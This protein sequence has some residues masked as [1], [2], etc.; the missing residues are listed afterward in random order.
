VYAALWH[1]LPGPWPV[2][3]VVLV[4]LAAAVVAACFLWVFPVAAP[5]LPF[6]QQTV[7]QE[8]DP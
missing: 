5:H 3:V 4:L 6:N 1:V 8:D 2:R 7:E